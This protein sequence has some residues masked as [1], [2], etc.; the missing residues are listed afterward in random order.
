MHYGKVRTVK[1]TCV[2]FQRQPAEN[3][4]AEYTETGAMNDL[5]VSYPA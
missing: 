5:A 2:A 1:N 3:G 4:M